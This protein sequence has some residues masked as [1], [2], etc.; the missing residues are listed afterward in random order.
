M[1]LVRFV[2]QAPAGK[3]GQIANEY[4]KNLDK[5]KQMMGGNLHL[6]ILTDLS[7]PFDTLVQEVTVESLAAW[8]KIRTAMFENPE[9]GQ[10]LEGAQFTYLSGR[11]EFYTIEAET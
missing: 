5:M 11:T 6:R 9:F 7:G 2:F 10:A 8:E 4:R 1:V 3:A